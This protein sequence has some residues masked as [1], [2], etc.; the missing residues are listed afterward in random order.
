MSRSKEKDLVRSTEQDTQGELVVS[1]KVQS[2]VLG[3]AG[4]KR[5]KPE[6][7]VTMRGL[8]GQAGQGKTENIY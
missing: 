2:V 6:A 3:E 1:L 8:A 7:D 5:S 4:T